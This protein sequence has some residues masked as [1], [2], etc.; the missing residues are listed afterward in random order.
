MDF[1]PETNVL[2]TGDEAGYLQCW[3]LQPMLEKLKNNEDSHKARNELERM[4]GDD[5][6]FVAPKSTTNR[7]DKTSSTFLTGVT[8]RENFEDI[9]YDNDTDVI[10]SYPCKAHEDAINCVTYIPELK[11]VATCAFDYHVYI[12]DAK[13]I[14]PVKAFKKRNKPLLQFDDDDDDLDL[15]E[16]KREEGK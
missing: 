9:P 2:Y 4:R 3:N 10:G 14:K 15:E 5:P 13:N 11:L 16:E 12:W 6:F 1:N 7:A 8:N